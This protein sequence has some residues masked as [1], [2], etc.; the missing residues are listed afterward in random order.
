M[1]KSRL[2]VFGATVAALIIMISVF[3][4]DVAKSMRLGLDLQGGFEIVYQITPLKEGDKLPSMSAVA[5]SISK[6]ID[7]LGV[8]EPDISVEGDDRVRVQLAGVSDIAQARKL[9]SSTANLSFRDV[10]DKLLMDATVLKKGGASLS[11]DPQTG[12]PAVS[13][14]IAD[15]DKFF[16][17]TSEVSTNA[18]GSNLMVTWLDFDPEKDSYSAESQKENPKYVSSATVSSGIKGD[19]V[20]NG[21]FTKEEARQM[22]ELI[23]SGSLPF[24][25]SEMYSNAVTA[26]YGENAFTATIFAGGVGVAFVMLFM[27]LFYRLPGIISAI[28]IAVYV[29]FVFLIYNAMGG[30]FTLSGIAALVLGVGMAVDSSI[31]T[32]ERIK[33]SLWAGRSVKSAFQEGTSKSFFTILDS[34]LT[35]FISALI[36]YLLGTG[37]VRGFATMLIVSVIATFLLI[38]FV[39]RFLLK[40]IIDSKLVDDKRSWFGVKDSQIANVSK[41]EEQFYFG[42]LKKFDFVKNSK[43]FIIT[44][45][46]V[47]V[48]GLGCSLFQGMNGNGPLNLG[49]DFTS[50]T[51]ITVQSDKKID[52]KELRDIFAKSNVKPA[53]IKLSGD[54]SEIANVTIKSALDSKTMNGLKKDLKATYKHDINDNIVT[55]VI[56][57]ELVKNAVLISLLAWIGILI[58]ISFRFKWD[59]AVSGIVGLLHDVFIILAFC[60]I[61]RIEV[62]TEIIAVMLAIIGYSINNSIVVFDRIREL[63]KQHHRSEMTPELYREVVNGSLQNTLVRSGLSSFTTLLPVICLLLMGSSAISTFCLALIIGLVS[64][65]GSSMFISSQLWYYIRTHVKVKTKHKK[66]HKKLDELTEMTIPGVND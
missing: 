55:P 37:S 50:G 41:G 32:F 40:L 3:S 19:A 5:E 4:S 38:V 46:S 23:N 6:R 29:F 54:K 56:G 59:Y 7:I 39:V 42:P 9:I 8:N 51:K 44:A 47:I 26:D 18:S 53:Q 62:N 65:T 49:I 43:Y 66:K 10:N 28:S 61:L 36:L 52:E 31:I 30:V 25:M 35:T 33:D 22:S 27:I 17:V 14:K 1:K 60:A 24:Q 45:I 48:I 34:Q 58:Y 63:L 2:Y 13:L 11:Y 20:I 57:R 16:D 12:T 64:G 21:N 15:Q